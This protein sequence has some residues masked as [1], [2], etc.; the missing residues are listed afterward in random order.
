LKGRIH[1]Y[2]ILFLAIFPLG[3]RSQ[4]SAGFRIAGVVHDATGGV[5]PGAEVTLRQSNQ[6]NAAMPLTQQT[7]GQGSFQFSVPAAGGYAV[8][9]RVANFAIYRAQ[10][11]VS[12]ETPSASLDVTL[13]V[14]GS[15]ETVEVTADA[16]AAETTSTQL[17]ETLES[18]K[19]RGRTAERPQFY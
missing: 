4:A 10:A 17:G 19:N 3:L 14:N 8:E 16:L 11:T 13:A 15:A 5:I 2:F 6:S 7:D 1:L 18:K 9:V 12:A